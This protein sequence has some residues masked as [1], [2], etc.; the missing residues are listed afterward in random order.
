M[1]A[2]Q[3]INR[4]VKLEF[5]NFIGIN[6]LK[7]S[8]D[9]KKRSKVW[10]LIGAF[11]YLAVLMIVYMS[12]IAVTLCLAGEARAVPSFCAIIASML[13]FVFTIFRAG[14]TIFNE[15]SY[16]KL[17]GLPISESV[18][19]WSRLLFMYLLN[20]VMA[21][22]I[23]LPA[24]IVCGLQTG[25][26]FSYWILFVLGIL[27][28]PM[29]PIAVSSAVGA[30]IAALAS[31]MEHKNAASSVMT[32]IF[33]LAIMLVSFIPALDPS[34]TDERVL[35]MTMSAAGSMTAW[36]PPAALFGDGVFGSLTGF[37]GFAALSVCIFALFAW[38][39]LKNYARICRKLSA[40][41]AR[42]NY[43]MTEQKVTSP[44]RALYQ[45]ELRRYLQTPVYVTNTAVGYLM[46]IVFGIVML[47]LVNNG[48]FGNDPELIRMLGQISPLVIGVL[49]MMSS[50]TPASISI[51]GRQWWIVRSFPVT[52]K[53]MFDAK[54]L[55]NLTMAIP[56]CLVS[57]VLCAV[58]FGWKYFPWLLLVP[59]SF[60]LL[61][62]VCGLAVNLKFPQF[63]WDNPTEVVK[64]GASMFAA[65]ALFF[66][67]AGLA[68][69]IFLTLG[70]VSYFGA[71]LLVTM[72]CLGGAALLYRRIL[73]TDLRKIY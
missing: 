27:F 20:L 10:I 59:V 34:M 48:Q 58:A 12:G 42:R 8:K 13:I 11:A 69:V 17:I 62:S 25:A 43:V 37:L 9:K 21:A 29:I 4:L 22:L 1:T 19:V 49:M 41:H 63:E 24:G 46:I 66:A 32:L 40:H 51:E 31:R 15:R 72:L 14:S 60:S 38:I 18:I 6:V 39:I 16:E 44:L 73:Q 2:V 50:T 57:A 30:V 54:I 71:M 55:T 36:Y 70:S 65:V 33:I 53:L 68:V 56:S 3:Q 61:A 67:S 23:M 28:I 7:F 35:G 64:Q 26:G 52:P 47:V 45:M 5:S